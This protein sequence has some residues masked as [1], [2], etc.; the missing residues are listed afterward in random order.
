MLP[1]RFAHA[2]HCVSYGKLQSR[3]FCSPEVVAFRKAAES[4]LSSRSSC[5]E[6][7][8]TGLKDDFILVYLHSPCDL[9]LGAPMPG[10]FY[11][12][13]SFLNVRGTVVLHRS[14]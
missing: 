5:L 12:L 2:L 14:A 3:F 4:D 8:A 13:L 6:I 11:F 10:A 9:P 7:V 1:S